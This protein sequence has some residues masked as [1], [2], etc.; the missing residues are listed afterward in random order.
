MLASGQYL[1][2]PYDRISELR[3]CSYRQIRHYLCKREKWPRLL[4]K[5]KTYEPSHLQDIVVESC[6]YM[7]SINQLNDPFDSQSNI[8]FDNSGVS[9]NKYIRSLIKSHKI[10]NKERAKPEKRLHSPTIIQ[11]ELQRVRKNIVD[12]TGIFSFSAEARNLLLWAH[13]ANSHKG[14]CLIF[15]VAQDIDVFVQSLPIQYSKSY[16]VIKYSENLK[17]DLIRATF[18]TK[19]NDWSYENE[20]RIFNLDRAHQKLSFNP[21]ALYGLIIG[22]K[23]DH[24]DIELIRGLVAKRASLDRPKLKIFHSEISD[25]KYKVIYRQVKNL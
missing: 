2:E 3:T 13:Y 5:Y 9:R 15:D 20:R 10:P 8:Y 17:S 11:N 18:L 22:A 19:A 23:S 24:N 7:S 21:R 25:S 4:F 12:K 1:A 14:V 16:P 6:L